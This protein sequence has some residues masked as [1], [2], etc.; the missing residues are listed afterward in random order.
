MKGQGGFV[1]L[2]FRN[3]GVFGNIDIWSHVQHHPHP[4]LP[5]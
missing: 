1:V 5:L 3:N 2:R 4:T